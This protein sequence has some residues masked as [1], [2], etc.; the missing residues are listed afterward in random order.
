VVPGWGRRVLNR[1]D[2]RISLEEEEEILLV[3]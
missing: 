3:P 1:V 2:L